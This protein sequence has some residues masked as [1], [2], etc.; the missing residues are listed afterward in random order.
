[1]NKKT[2]TLLRTAGIT[3]T[4]IGVYDLPN[5]DLF[6]PFTRPSDCLFFDFKDWQDNKSTMISKDNSTAFS[7]PGAGHWM[8][9]ISAMPSEAVAGYLAGQEG[10]KASEET[11]CQW[12]EN[13]PPYHMENNAIVI[14]K[15]RE[16]HYEYLKTVTFFVTPDQ[17]SL[18]ITG[19]E[20]F[21]SAPDRGH[22]TAAY[23]SGCG[24]LLALFTDFQRPLAMIGATDI[25]M[26]QHLPEDI[27]AFTVTKPM[28]EQLCGLDEKSFLYKSFWHRLKEAR[29]SD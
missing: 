12:L 5:P 21:H 17:L 7:C 8:C 6:A 2:N 4:P 23:G 22:I 27:L 26:R 19:A 1:M 13:H 10:L 3:H 16:D 28:F 9:G 15:L 11:M 20:Y 29:H 14:S 24:Q 25:A 18:L